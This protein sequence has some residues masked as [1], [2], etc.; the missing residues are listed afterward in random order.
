MPYCNISNGCS[1]ILLSAFVFAIRAPFGLP[2]DD[3]PLAVA[4]D[5]FNRRSDY[6]RVYVRV[7]GMLLIYVYPIAI[8]ETVEV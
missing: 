6:L 2:R 3:T 1:H 5:K 4:S 7:L 8:F